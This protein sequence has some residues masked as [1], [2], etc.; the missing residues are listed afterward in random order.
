M[1]AII[2]LKALLKVA[3][4]SAKSAAVRKASISGVIIASG[5]SEVQKHN[6]YNKP[7]EVHKNK[8]TEIK[9]I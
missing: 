1:I 6:K 3:A 2:I 4:V 7:R 9:M 5:I 8:E